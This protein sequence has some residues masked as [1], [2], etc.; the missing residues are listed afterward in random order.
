MMKVY[1]WEPGRELI[2]N[3]DKMDLIR[4]YE[5]ASSSTSLMVTPLMM[6]RQSII[7][8]ISWLILRYHLVILVHKKIIEILLHMSHIS[9]DNFF[10]T[11]TMLTMI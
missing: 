2:S 3:I 6:P 5:A 4:G 9:K 10:V 8:T 7:K 11:K 1:H